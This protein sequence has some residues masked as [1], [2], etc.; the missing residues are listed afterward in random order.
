MLGAFLNFYKIYFYM[1]INIFL[2]LEQINMPDYLGEDM[3][4]EKKDNDEKKDFE[5]IINFFLIKI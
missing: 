3:R 2:F 5:G 1:N 4:K